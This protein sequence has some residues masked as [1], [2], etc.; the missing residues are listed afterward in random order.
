[1]RSDSAP[2]IVYFVRHCEAAG[3]EP[4]APLTAAGEA[5]AVA[6]ADFLAPFPIDR[7]LSSPYRR[8]RDCIA[9]LAAQRGLPIETDDRLV[10]RILTTAPLPDWRAHLRTSFTDLDYCLPG[11]ESSHAA[12]ARAVT[13]L[14]GLR[15]HPATTTVIVTHGNLL[16]LLLQH[17]DDRVGFTTWE[18]LTNP[19]VFAAALTEPIKP[20]RRI[21]M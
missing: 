14:N 6:L 8:A 1:V 21:W 5:Q 15:R 13:V 20:A 9:P 7:I 10:E 11:G 19:D 3:Q 12:Q 17:C 2:K 18:A 4:G 16:A